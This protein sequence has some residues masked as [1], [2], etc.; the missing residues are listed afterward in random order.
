MNKDEYL[1]LLDGKEK[2]NE[3]KK[4][5]KTEKYYIIEFYN[6]EKTY[7]YNFS[8]VLCE[9]KSQIL[10]I[11]ENQIVLLND[12]IISDVTK[13]IRYESKIRNTRS[14]VSEKITE[15]SKLSILENNNTST[16]NEILSYFRDISKY[17]KME[18]KKTGKYEYLLKEQ[19]KNFIVPEKSV[20]KYYLNGI[21]KEED[22]SKKI[23]IYPFNFNI[24]QKTAVENINKSNIS[25]IKGP[26]GTGKTQTILNI[27]ANLVVNNKTMAV[28]SGNNEATKN[29][30]EKLDKNGYGFIVA[31]LGNSDNVN[32]FFDNLP[33]IRIDNFNKKEVSDEIFQN[34]QETTNKLEKLLELNNE[35]CKLKRELANYELEQKYFEEYYKSQKINETDTKKIRKMSSSKIIDFLAYSKLAKEKYLQYKI[36]FNILLLLRFG[37]E[38]KKS[39]NMNYILTVQR[40]YYI[41]KINEIKTKIS[42]IEGQLEDKNFFELQKQ[43]TSISKK[44]FEGILYDKYKDMNYSPSKINYKKDF[45][46]FTKR[47]P[48]ILSTTFS[49]RYCTPSG[50]L[51]DYVI[52]DEASQVDLLTASLALSCAKNVIVV[53]DEKQLPQIVDT[54]IKSKIQLISDEKYDYFNEN[55]LTSILK[56]YNGK[57]P[58]RRLREHYRCHPKIIEFCNQRYYEGELI[59]YE[60]ERHALQ[61]NPLYIYY[62]TPGNHMRTLNNMVE[63][64]NYNQRELDILKN[65]IL[66]GKILKNVGKNDIGFTTPYRKQAYKASEQNN[67]IESNTIHKYQGKEKKVMILSTVLDSSRNGKMRIKFVDDPCMVNVAVSRA[68]EQFILI[69]NEKL[70]SEQSNEVKALIQYIKYNTL[71]K[72]IINSQIVSVF[73]LL[74][75]E[76]SP[77]LKWLQ[78]KLVQTSK[79]KSENIVETVLMRVL[80]AEKSKGLTYASQMYLRNI[81][82]DL[83]RLTE[84]ERKYVNHNASVDFIIYENDKEPKFCIEVDGFAFHANKPKQLA[85]DRMKDSIFKKY[86][87]DLIRLKTDESQIIN[88]IKEEI[89]KI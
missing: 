3:I 76:Y 50:Y 78:S 23:N 1:I 37:K 54:D 51:Y 72:N 73:D 44:I 48:V 14:S 11:K 22:I 4:I 58:I 82:N 28:V 21:S 83:S 9:K 34:L 79:F 57:I 30:K 35:E 63:K 17:V 67:E 75:K 43:H 46:T 69:T 33:S 40:Q 16:E 85:N 47:F 5:T 89:E 80:K 74:Y 36:I 53:G 42:E 56:L 88:K 10:L 71:D 7:K 65:E 66:K 86:N 59:P 31:E 55:I 32:D 49:L 64:G 24:S 19:Y 25:V 41:T 68:K 61:K 15:A 6:S 62:P 52:I 45:K 18:N 12:T 70:F 84:D 26:P 38:A 8:K 87:L 77:K 81:F 29:V 27:I 2:T 20:L 39:K 13:I 60:N